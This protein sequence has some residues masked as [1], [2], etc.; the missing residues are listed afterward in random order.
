MMDDLS[1]KLNVLKIQDEKTLAMKEDLK[2]EE[3]ILDLR[4]PY[5]FVI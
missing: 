4:C 3:E 2:L 5:T 1:K